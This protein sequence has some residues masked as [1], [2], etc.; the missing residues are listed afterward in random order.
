V[1]TGLPLV[2]ITEGRVIV[3]ELEWI[4]KDLQQTAEEMEKIEWEEDLM[5][6]ADW[7]EIQPKS[8]EVKP[9]VRTKR[10]EPGKVWE[11]EG[12]APGTE[13]GPQRWPQSVMKIA[14]EKRWKTMEKREES[15]PRTDG[16]PPK[17]VGKQHWTQI[18]GA[19][20]EKSKK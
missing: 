5:E 12:E 8:E 15:S 1:P 2:A 13:L 19:L 14:A 9:T 16:A 11:E 7:R 17:V 10:K 3:G 18:Y 6:D 4:E 20:V